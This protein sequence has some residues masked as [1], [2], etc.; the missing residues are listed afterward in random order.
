M[1][2]TRT[3]GFATR[4]AVENRTPRHGTVP[5]ERTFAMTET[6]SRSVADAAARDAGLYSVPR[7]AG[8]V[9]D[10]FEMRAP[11]RHEDGASPTESVYFEE[12]PTTE[13]A[14]RELKGRFCAIDGGYIARVVKSEP[15]FNRRSGDRRVQGIV[16]FD[17]GCF[18]SH[19]HEEDYVYDV[20]DYS[21][22]AI[23]TRLFRA[24]FVDRWD[25]NHPNLLGAMRWI[26]EVAPNGLLGIR[27]S[28]YNA[29]RHLH[30]RYLLA[31]PN[32]VLPS[33]LHH[34]TVNMRPLVAFSIMEA[35]H[36]Q[37]AQHGLSMAH[38]LRTDE[39]AE[40]PLHA[41]RWNEHPQYSPRVWGD[42]DAAP[43]FEV[44]V[45]KAV[46]NMMASMR[47]AKNT[48][49]SEIEGI[50]ITK[51]RSAVTPELREQLDADMT[52]GGCF[53]AT[54]TFGW[55]S[56][57]VGRQ[58]RKQFAAF[59]KAP[60][61]RRFC[62]KRDDL[63]TSS[64]VPATDELDCSMRTWPMGA[65]EGVEARA[66]IHDPDEYALLLEDLEGVPG[67]IVGTR[68]Q[69]APATVSQDVGENASVRPISIEDEVS[70]PLD[71]T[72]APLDFI[73]R[74]TRN[75][76]KA[77]S[78]ALYTWI[79]ARAH[80]MA[81]VRLLFQNPSL[82]VNDTLR[83]A[84]GA[85]RDDQWIRC[86]FAKSTFSMPHIASQFSSAPDGR[87]LVDGQYFR[88][89]FPQIPRAPFFVQPIPQPRENESTP[90]HDRDEMATLCHVYAANTHSALRSFMRDHGQL[91]F[92]DE[93]AMQNGANASARGRTDWRFIGAEYPV[94]NP[95]TSVHEVR[96]V[97]G[98][99]LF[100]ES[101]VDAV[102]HANWTNVE[103][104]AIV[105]ELADD[106][107]GRVIIVEYKMLMEATKCTPRILSAKNQMQA[108]TNAFMFYMCVGILP[109]HC[110]VVHSTR[111]ADYADRPLT[112]P[113]TTSAGSSSQQ[114]ENVAYITLLRVD[115]TSRYQM[116]LF[117]RLLTC[118]HHNLTK[119]DMTYMDESHFIISPH[120]VR[121]VR[122]PAYDSVFQFGDSATDQRARDMP[123]VFCK[124]DV[125]C[126]EFSVTR[127]CVVLH[128]FHRR[129]WHPPGARHVDEDDGRV[130]HA[131][132][133]TSTQRS[134]DIAL[135]DFR[136]NR[137]N[138]ALPREWRRAISP[139]LKLPAR[140]TNLRKGTA[141]NLPSIAD[142]DAC[143]KLWRMVSLRYNLLRADEDGVHHQPSFAVVKRVDVYQKRG[144][145][146][147]SKSV[148]GLQLTPHDRR[149]GEVDNAR[150]A[151]FVTPIRSTIVRDD[152]GPIQSSE[153]PEAR[154]P[155]PRVNR[156]LFAASIQFD[157]LRV[158]IDD[159]DVGVLGERNYEDEP[160]ENR[161]IRRNVNE[162]VQEYAET[163]AREF[164][165]HDSL[166]LFTHILDMRDPSNGRRHFG[167]RDDEFYNPDPEEDDYT[168]RG[169]T[170]VMSR[171]IHRLLN[172]RIHAAISAL[173]CTPTGSGW[174]EGP[175]LEPGYSRI[176]VFPHVS[177]R[178]MWSN[179]ALRLMESELNEDDREDVD[180]D[181]PPARRVIDVAVEDLR[182]HLR[183]LNRNGSEERRRSGNAS[184]S[185]HGHLRAR[186]ASEASPE[187]QISQREM[188]AIGRRPFCAT[189]GGSETDV[190]IEWYHAQSI[191]FELPSHPVNVTS[192]DGQRPCDVSPATYPVN[193]MD[194]IPISARC[195]DLHTDLMT[196]LE[197][198][199]RSRRND[200]TQEASRRAVQI[201]RLLR[202]YD[203]VRRNGEMLVLESPA[204]AAC[205][206]FSLLFEPM[207]AVYGENRYRSLLAR[208]PDPRER[209]F[210]R[211]AQGAQHSVEDMQNINMIAITIVHESNVRCEAWL[212]VRVAGSEYTL[213]GVV[214]RSEGNHFFGDILRWNDTT[215]SV[216]RAVRLFRSARIN[217]GVEDVTE[218]YDGVRRPADGGNDVCCALPTPRNAVCCLLLYCRRD[219]SDPQHPRATNAHEGTACQV[220]DEPDRE[221]PR[222]LW[223]YCSRDDGWPPRRCMERSESWILCPV[224]YEAAGGDSESPFPREQMRQTHEE[225][226][227]LREKWE[228]ILVNVRAHLIARAA[229]HPRMDKP[230]V[231][232]RPTDGTDEVAISAWLQSYLHSYD[233]ND[234]F[235]VC[236]SNQISLLGGD[237]NEALLNPYRTELVHLLRQ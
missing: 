51:A 11:Q 189:D 106:V 211:S 68:R 110:L 77:I 30:F 4:E 62:C 151:A 142:E 47:A 198:F 28:R 216:R 9:F 54:C 177:D 162:C 143:H 171:S 144:G 223:R 105:S 212:D 210:T 95:Y 109:S 76:R 150:R 60:T 69:N 226:P 118:P 5:T 114:S 84:N 213:T 113:P 126:P 46:G 225:W 234:R 185:L 187:E 96:H 65:E 194:T 91:L 173:V 8:D 66:E 193:P 17:F 157:M 18:V 219:C 133:V 80:E 12:W 202:E 154:R 41:Q 192:T 167:T 67:S 221:L 227:S 169:R 88:D 181:L 205:R 136:T 196:Q 115:L 29:F 168:Y 16:T 146:S 224:L 42:P 231:L 160:D 186:R 141:V 215:E 163:L 155:I 123:E 153:P 94:Y 147:L 161:D 70:A 149:D 82:E 103:N 33:Y 170:S 85:H 176:D 178:G 108:L 73:Q 203:A 132:R 43:L 127:Y 129:L 93:R 23:H 233:H 121:P 125:R 140:N 175:S 55:S 22:E 26:T 7:F 119:Y 158:P 120:N 166:T 36:A 104:A 207:A 1:L 172:V 97:A 184:R 74:K 220:C 89:I 39:F 3:Y 152:A 164:E 40:A 204:L 137:V 222:H 235:Y 159:S 139:L 2:R 87:W 6:T 190:V 208:V 128:E 131:T 199:C 179:F 100:F 195:A 37:R 56:V 229:S 182:A 101:R 81:F 14:F 64:S 111:R 79:G 44:T 138:V 35:L 25:A 57:R 228:R 145:R 15:R 48:M 183:T 107:K 90:L 32:N 134:I 102:V 148:F 237:P 49:P 59:Q 124:D 197:E 130:R 71:E 99:P 214:Y 86:A 98:P 50:L 45:A 217:E 112:R 72:F 165:N 24:D 58:P 230:G 78:A 53:P 20:L 117:Q 52:Y 122:Q 206:A 61:L 174:F 180:Q 21:E 83:L 19:D 209:R 191:V 156:S 188:R 116:R 27:C 31:R 201:D 232:P 218:A 236:P 92:S 75:V 38:S 135:Q 63:G 13:R 10:L 34:Y 200:D